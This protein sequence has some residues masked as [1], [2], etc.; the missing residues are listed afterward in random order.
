[1]VYE[2]S[3][4]HIKYPRLELR[5]GRLLLVLP[6]GCDPVTV[7]DKHRGW[8]HAKA[9]FISEC[10]EDSLN[11]ELA[12]RSDAEFKSLVYTLAEKASSELA[13]KVNGVFFR[14][15]KTK[16]ASCSAKGNLT[17]NKLMKRLP[18]ELINYVI[19][20]EVAHLIERKHNEIFWRIV[21]KKFSN[22]EAIERDLFTY[23]FYCRPFEEPANRCQTP[24]S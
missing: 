10:L 20:H 13:V 24:V 1:V 19:F 2:V 17:V 14:L 3:Y 12:N 8:V 18:E 23:W 7:L 6:F 22:I 15:M 11:K 9:K 21:S 4:R 5:T 16:W